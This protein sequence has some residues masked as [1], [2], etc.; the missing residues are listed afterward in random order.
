[1]IAKTEHE[2]AELRHA[3]KILAEVLRDLMLLVKSGVTTAAL[4]LA[5]EKMIRDE[6]AIPAFLNY[7]PSGA[8]F[9][10]PAA[11]CISVNDEVV[12]GIPSEEHV[13]KDGDIV[14]LDLGL[15]YNGYFVDSAR[16]QFVGAG[17]DKADAKGQKLMDATRESLAAGI[18]AVK[19]GGYIGDIGAAVEAVAKRYGFN[20]VEELGGHAL[21]KTVHEKPFISNVGKVGEGEKIV[22]GYV[23]AL[24]PIFAEGKGRISLLED[25]WTY[26]TRDGSRAAHFEQTI[27]VTK[28]GAE[29]LTP[30]L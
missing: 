9:P 5:A 30:F 17:H 3:G 12:H 24:E 4:D 21:G 22:E 13:L 23:L 18:S 25:Q 8:K 1:M 11:L 14:S 19:V 29:I 16:T 6:G 28:T 26:V 20:V 27:L 2:I 10:F 15:S 7:K